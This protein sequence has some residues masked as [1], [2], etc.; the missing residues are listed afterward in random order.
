MLHQRFPTLLQENNILLCRYDF[1]KKEG[2]LT[3]IA[4]LFGRCLILGKRGD[5]EGKS[6]IGVSS[7]VLHQLH[8]ATKV[9]SI[10]YVGLNLNRCIKYFLDK[11]KYVLVLVKN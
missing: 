3:F 7:T 8:L 1:G 5:L 10:F 2:R 9:E 6:K 11:L 4:F